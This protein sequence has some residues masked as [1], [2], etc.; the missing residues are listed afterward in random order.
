MIPAAN[1]ENN[2]KNDVDD[3][4]GFVEETPD[5]KTA[6]D[7]EN[8][9]T[10]CGDNAP[11]PIRFD[12]L[13]SII[14]ILT[15]EHQSQYRVKKDLKRENTSDPAM[16]QQVSG[17]RPNRQPE[18]NVISSREE[19][20]K[21]SHDV[22][23]VARA[24]EDEGDDLEPFGCVPGIGLLRLIIH[25]REDDIENDEHRDIESLAHG[26]SIAE[27]V[28]KRANMIRTDGARPNKIRSDLV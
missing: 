5:V 13:R 10:N 2:R 4:E 14:S 11:D 20:K 8:D 24:V 26:R 21:G 27:K 16:Q 3:Q 7:D 18:K 23:E 19:K 25:R 17:V 12:V 15:V 6:A 9:D 1:N 28:R 22:C